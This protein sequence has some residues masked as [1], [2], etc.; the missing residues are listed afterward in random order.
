LKVAPNNSDII[1]MG[2]EDG[3]F[4]STDRGASWAATGMAGHRV[5]RITID[6]R[7]PN[8]IYVATFRFENFDQPR[9]LSSVFKSTDGGQT[10]A[11]I[12]DA[13]TVSAVVV[14]PKDS[15][16]IYASSRTGLF[17]G[18]GGGGIFK[19][20]DEGRT[21]ASVFNGFDI[22]ERHIE[23]LA[24]DH[25]NPSVVYAASV[26]GVFKTTDAGATWKKTDLNKYILTLEIDP[27][28]P[29]ILYAGAEE[30]DDTG[31]SIEDPD[32]RFNP[33]RRIGIS[34]SPG[35]ARVFKSTDAGRSWQAAGEGFDGEEIVLDFVIDPRSPSTVYGVSLFDF[36]KTTDGGG[37][38][39]GVTNFPGDAKAAAV[40]PQRSTLYIGI[41]TDWDQ[42][43]FVAKLNPAGTELVYSSYLGTTDTDNGHSIAV[44]AQGNAYVIGETESKNFHLTP[45]AFDKQFVGTR[46]FFDMFFVKLNRAGEMVYSSYLGGDSVE[47][48]GGIAVGPDGAAYVVGSSGSKNLPFSN[49]L[50][51]EFLGSNSLNAFVAKINIPGNAAPRVPVIT[52]VSVS[53]KML[54][55]E[56]ENF[57]DGAVILVE[58]KQQQT[59]IDPASAGSKLMSKKAAKKV[60]RKPE[61]RVQ[62]RNSDGSMSVGYNYA[63]P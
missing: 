6:E 44:D 3:L 4:K 16:V 34:A 11:R 24:I 51:T 35:A 59:V 28:N 19:S 52:R 13:P 7:N 49:P 37:E 56:G 21:W 38:W 1:Y 43:A 25:N 40:D 63:Q 42:D 36:Y 15:A 60:K 22:S 2:N 20:T 58:G 39:T 18:E 48:A 57:D 5:R 9:I 10:W 32:Q 62:V 8:T 26:R 29:A 50:R 41:D 53:G 46:F 31:A 30:D 45:N 47:Y 55:V 61:A 12:L 14:N 33:R 27:S 54:V 17:A 23:D